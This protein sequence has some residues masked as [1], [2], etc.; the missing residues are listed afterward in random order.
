MS[1]H[2]KHQITQKFN[3]GSDPDKIA[4]SL[5]QDSTHTG[6]PLVE[7]FGLEDP[8]LR[9]TD[10]PPRLTD[11][12]TPE[13]Q[14]AFRRDSEAARVRSL[15]REEY[16][17]GTTLANDLAAVLT[18]LSAAEGWRLHTV[19]LTTTWCNYVLVRSK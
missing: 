9:D 11:P 8:A 3:E 12:Y 13:E 2:G 10:P 19:S 4:K 7:V 16:L 17:T 14:A 18:E 5:V 15:P 1:R 6:K